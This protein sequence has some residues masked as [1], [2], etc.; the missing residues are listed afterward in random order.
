MKYEHFVIITFHHSR[1]LYRN[2]DPALHA[3][4]FL[5][6]KRTPV[7]RVGMMVT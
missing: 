5:D 6:L 4:C 1:S 7:A 3:N 2:I